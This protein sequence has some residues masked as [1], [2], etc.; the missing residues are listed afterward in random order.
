[1]A[2]N[3][4][5][6]QVCIDQRLE[7]IENKLSE[8]HST[9]QKLSDIIKS[10]ETQLGGYHKEIS[11]AISSESMSVDKSASAA[12]LHVSEDSVAQIAASLVTEQ[13]EKE[14]RQINIIVY[15]VEE[16]NASDGP[17]R[18]LDDIKKCVS[19]FQ[20]YLGL[21]V[22]ITNA[23]RLGQRSDKSTLL[24]VS[25]KDKASIL[26]NKIKLRSTSNPPNIRNVFITPDLTPTEQKKTQST[27]A[28][29]SWHEQAWKV[30]H[31]K[32]QE[33]NAEE[34]LNSLHTDNVVPSFPLS[35]DHDSS[36][37]LSALIVN[38]QSLVSKKESFQNLINAH[39]P[40]VIFGTESW[41][42]SDVKVSEV[43][44]NGY[45]FYQKD[46]DDGYGGVFVACRETL[47]T[48]DIQLTISSSEL[49]ACIFV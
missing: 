40:D 25:L 7:S 2:L 23:F 48:S 15:N 22:S 9:K 10:I 14:R 38:Y 20:S 32:K 33:N 27:E 17:A 28:A 49:V 30:L 18:K 5:E 36:H 26:K 1:M 35:I 11:T 31:D 37:S 29:V 21:S 19:M 12:S 43:F 24:K 47:A 42:K 3:H 8:V 16:S 41:L 13:K 39:S 46:W 6:T 44:T 4:Y 34:H 45:V